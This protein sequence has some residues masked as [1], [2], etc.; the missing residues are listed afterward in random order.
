MKWQHTPTYE[1][2][3]GTR[4]AFKNRERSWREVTGTGKV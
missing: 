1:L 2:I 4:P 3:L